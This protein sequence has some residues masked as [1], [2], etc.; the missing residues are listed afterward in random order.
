MRCA[1]QLG[2][3]RAMRYEKIEDDWSRAGSPKKARDSDNSAPVSQIP[4]LRAWPSARSGPRNP[5]GLK[6]LEGCA[7]SGC[8]ERET[9]VSRAD[10]TH[11]RV[12]YR[13][14]AA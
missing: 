9:R 10:P 1:A 5:S 12:T 6:S 13:L 11:I 2:E 7:W 3:E 4:A 8:V 14:A